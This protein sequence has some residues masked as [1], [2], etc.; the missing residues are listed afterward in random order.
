MSVQN[1]EQNG[2]RNRIPVGYQIATFQIPKDVARTWN[3]F[4]VFGLELFRLLFSQFLGICGDN[5]PRRSFST[6]RAF[7]TCADILTL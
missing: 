2:F 4:Q 1:G 5:I 6:L 3:A 7:R